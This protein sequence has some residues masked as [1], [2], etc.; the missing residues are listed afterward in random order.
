MTIE[1]ASNIYD[2]N[3]SLPAD[4]DEQAEGDDHIRMIKAALKASLPGL[5]G[6]LHRAI[7]KSTGFTPAL[8]EN[9]CVYDCTGGITATFLAI[10]GVPD[11]THYWINAYSGTVTLDPNGAELIN[12]AATVVLP[13]GSWAF[14]FK[15]G[16]AWHAMLGSG[17]LSTQVPATVH[18]A[19]SKATPVDADE[20]PLVDSAAS[21]GLKRLTWANLKTALSSFFMALVAPGASGNIL[22]SNGSAWASAAPP[23]S[24]VTSVNGNT[25]AI[26][27][28]QIA[29]AATAGYSYTPARVGT[30]F[31][32]VLVY[33]WNV[34]CPPAGVSINPVSNWGAGAYQIVYSAGNNVAVAEPDCIGVVTGSLTV[35]STNASTNSGSFKIYRLSKT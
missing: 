8:T 10:A 12:G 34:E 15:L 20:L 11:G 26:S 14:V 5:Q 16:T 32:S 31:T 3:S 17:D 13:S 35:K 27:A 24:G 29:E 2:L 6:A 1:T 19:T 7:A 22:T 28:A 33:T 25:G 4:G 21:Y 23:A 9:G 30:G 18:A